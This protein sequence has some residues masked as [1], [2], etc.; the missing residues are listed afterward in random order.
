[1]MTTTPDSMNPSPLH[2]S[3][4]E[5]LLAEYVEGTLRGAAK[6]SLESHLASCS[7]CRELA[8]DA[9]AAAS[10]LARTSVLEVPPE[11][12]NRILFQVPSLKP[13][14][15]RRIFGQVLGGWLE[16]VLQPRLAMGMGVAAL[17]F[18]MLEPHVRQLTL[19][20]L[21][22][23]KTWT[24]TENRANRVW[25]R[26]VKSYENLRLVYE[27][28]SRLNEWQQEAPEALNQ[29]EPAKTSAPLPSQDHK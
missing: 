17:S 6:A 2:C 9:A 25:E 22:P 27:I 3:D 5:I 4:A 21:D 16:P 12:V 26:G 8:Q 10:F 11:L 15:A 23:V 7:S 28:Q 29:G 20:D 18:F 19:A 13:S 1:M 24:I 14:L